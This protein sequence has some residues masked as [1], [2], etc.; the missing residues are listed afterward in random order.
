MVVSGSRALTAWLVALVVVL[1]GLAVV[2]GLIV[3]RTHDERAAE[4][5]REQ[6]YAAVLAA[7]SAEA[8]A[9]VNIDYTDARSSIDKVAAGATGQFRAQY[10]TATGKV[11]RTL[12]RNHSRMDGTVLWAGVVSVDANRATVLVATDGTVANKQSGNKPVERDFRLRLDLVLKDGRWL[13]EDL[14]VVR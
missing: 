8:E 9:F 1:A 10:G 6:R 11:V 2:G 12:D 13:T 4:R 7:A 5:V 14:G 3:R